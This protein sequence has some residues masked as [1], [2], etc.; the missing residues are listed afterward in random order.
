VTAGLGIARA[1]LEEVKKKFPEI[2][3]A[4]LYTLASVVAIEEMG[5]PKVSWRPGRTDSKVISWWFARST[6]GSFRLVLW[7]GG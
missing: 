1:R 3:Y 6:P 4:D 5:G 2:S 7:S